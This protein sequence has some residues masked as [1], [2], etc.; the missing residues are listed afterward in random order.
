MWDAV[1]V[2]A[3]AGA[4]GAAALPLTRVLLVGLP[5]AGAGIARPLAVLLAG[6]A[7]WLPVSLGVVP[8]TAL[9]AWLGVLA[10]LLAGAALARRTRRSPGPATAPLTRQLVLGAEI[11]FVVFFALGCLLTAYSPD[12]VGTEKPM[13]MMLLQTSMTS[14]HLPP[15]DL[16]LA[17]ED[18]NYYYLGSWLVGFV[19]KVAAVAPDRG[20]NVGLGLV[21]GLSAS[22]VFGV[23]GALAAAVGGPRRA[24][25][26]AMVATGLTMLAGN[27]QGLKLV[28]EHDGPLKTLNWF[29]A[30]RV[31]PGGADDF[32]FFATLLGDLHAHLI[33][34]PFTVL[35]IALA[36]HAALAGPLTRRYAVARLALSSLAVGA[37][38]AMHTWTYPVALALLLAAGA[39]GLRHH[40]GGCDVSATPGVRQTSHPLRRARSWAGWAAA[41]VAGSV[42]LYLPFHLTFDPS[43][44]GVGRVRDPPS[45]VT[46]LERVGLTHGALVA[47]ALLAVAVAAGGTTGWRAAAGGPSFGRDRG[48]PGARA[49][50]W[51]LL[52]AGIGCLLVPQVVFVR[53]AFDGG[54][55]YRFNTVFK[56][57]FQAWPL[58]G[59]ACGAAL[60]LVL[61]GAGRRARPVVGVA[62]AVAA[63]ASAVFPVAGSIARTDGFAGPPRLGGLRWMERAAPGDAAAIRW[64]RLHVP[65]DA[66]VLE[67]A[68]PEYSY[69]G[70]IA[71][72]SGR[73]TVIAWAGHELVWGQPLGSREADVAAVYR[74]TDPIATR[75]LLRRY[76]VRFVVVG[77]YER[78]TYPGPGLARGGGARPARVLLRR[79]GGLPRGRRRAAGRR[80][81][82]GGSDGRRRQRARH[83][84]PS[85]A[86]RVRPASTSREGPCLCAP[87]SRTSPP[88]IT[89][90]GL[91]ASR[92]TTRSHGA[93][94]T[95]RSQRS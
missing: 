24:L 74:S 79:H 72:F 19:M 20:Y 9:T 8:Y 65:A 61:D 80:D 73:S 15:R 85:R 22:A 49:F 87:G 67:A 2:L 91:P 47:I 77:D 29:A 38:F 36:L 18:L 93:T 88:P 46:F 78:E 75:A 13:D 50:L 81:A 60:V 70:R 86:T 64:I 12:I 1:K 23:A 41:L 14:E 55:N 25:P 89:L 92:T 66:V 56:F 37:L 58:L 30:S 52:A 4:L 95:S 32:P 10:V 6:F 11:T 59:V 83:G 94:R 27:A 31:T 69:G 35:V 42:L 40:R 76:A 17:G 71:T 57:G 28:L 21:F 43:P 90:E 82:V 34:V 84:P 48:Q 16:W 53:D 62:V 7:V 26:A 39:V 45:P 68:G 3:V 33:A 5:G 63:V 54:P 44:G 51:L